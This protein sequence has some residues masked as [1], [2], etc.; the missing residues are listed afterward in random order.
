MKKEISQIN[1]QRIDDLIIALNGADN[2]VPHNLKTVF[3]FKG[4]KS[5]EI[6]EIA[7]RKLSDENDIILDPFMGSAAFTIA[8]VNAGRKIISTE[9]DNYTYNAVYSLF[10]KINIRKLN[11]LFAKLESSVKAEVM[12]LYETSCC[13][14]K[15][16]ISKVLFD[17]ETQEYF[18]PT[19]NRENI[20]RNL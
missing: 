9:I 19:P 6:A 14:I 10:A 2:K 12:G 20:N 18:N 4:R 8:S 7:I 3:N 5:P 16:Y 17:P 15:N 13:G 1:K 11:S